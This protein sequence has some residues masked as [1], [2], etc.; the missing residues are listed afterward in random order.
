VTKEC[1]GSGSVGVMHKECT[2]NGREVV[3]Y[4]CPTCGI[5]LPYS[6]IKD[7]HRLRD[8]VR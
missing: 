5:L 7:H 6:P 1:P 8:G 3:Y 4:E 2:E